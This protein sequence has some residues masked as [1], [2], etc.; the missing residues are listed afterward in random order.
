MA[1]RPRIY[2]RNGDG[3]VEPGCKKRHF[4]AGRCCG[5]YF[6]LRY[7]PVSNPETGKNVAAKNVE[8]WDKINAMWRRWEDQE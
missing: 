4:K 2:P 1:G 6:K 7:T 3:C 5:H 8:A